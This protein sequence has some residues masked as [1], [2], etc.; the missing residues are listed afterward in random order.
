MD[1]NNKLAIL[2]VDGIVSLAERDLLPA[3]LNLRVIEDTR[4][5][6][7]LNLCIFVAVNSECSDTLT[8]SIF[9]ANY[10][11]NRYSHNLSSDM[12]RTSTL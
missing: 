9:K 2:E 5:S 11:Y 8:T 1:L 7:Q 3:L 6:Q 4:I 12:Q 10:I